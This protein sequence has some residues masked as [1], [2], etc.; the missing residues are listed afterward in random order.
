MTSPEAGTQTVSEQISQRLTG[1]TLADIPAKA[2]EVGV[3]DLIGLERERDRYRWLRENFDP[4][5]HIAYSLLVYDVPAE[6]V[7][8][9][10]SDDQ[11][12]K[13]GR[14]GSSD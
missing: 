8:H 12:G 6:R 1:L 3:N 11:S 10:R 9:F 4:I 7:A 2:L 5:D 13:A 14:G